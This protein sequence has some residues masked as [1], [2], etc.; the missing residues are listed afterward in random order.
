MGFSRSTT[1]E[2]E[3]GF[4]KDVLLRAREKGVGLNV[5]MSHLKANSLQPDIR[6]A[7]EVLFKVEETMR[8]SLEQKFGLKNIEIRSAL[9]EQTVQILKDTAR[10]KGFLDPRTIRANEYMNLHE[11]ENNGIIIDKPKE[12][13]LER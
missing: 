4:I 11:R 7:H 2:N 12:K 10:L 13:E 5:L 3:R 8:S 9:L 6:V 1:P